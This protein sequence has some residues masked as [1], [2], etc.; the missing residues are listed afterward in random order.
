MAKIRFTFILSLVGLML[1][2]CSIK[3]QSSTTAEMVYIPGGTFQMGSNHGDDDE[4]PVHTV[5]LSPYWID[6]TEV[7]NAMY[8]QCVQDGACDPPSN[9]SSNTRDNYFGNSK[10]DNFPVIYV[11]WYDAKAYCEWAGKQLPTEAQ[12]E[13][14]ARGTDGRIYPWGDSII[15]NSANFCDTNCPFE[16]KTK[17]YNDGYS[18]TA[19]VGSYESGKSPFGV[20]D[21]AGNVFEWVADWYGMYLSSSQTDPTGPS[22]GDYR[23]LRGGAWYIDESGIRTSFRPWDAP[24]YSYDNYGFRCS[25]T[26]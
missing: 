24:D 2:G 16:W 26:P 19:P 17:T 23:V 8:E 7:T 20:Y 10:Y 6:S 12:W 22:S 13:F 21:M 14:A 15:N 5:T 1:M 3:E 9:T 25:L 11:S 4:Q 18:D